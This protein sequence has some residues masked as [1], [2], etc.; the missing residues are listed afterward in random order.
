MVLHGYEDSFHETSSPWFGDL[1]GT[2][3]VHFVPRL[4]AQSKEV[5]AM[6][7]LVPDTATIIAD[8]RKLIEE[9]RGRASRKVNAELSLL[10][11]NVGLRLRL[12]A[13]LSERA[14]YGAKILA[15]VSKKL[16]EDFGRGWSVTQLRYCLRLQKCSPTKFLTH[17]VRN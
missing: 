1:W 11:W 5:S 10:Y 12:E 3:F 7:D 13:G 15:R 14:E 8:L 6:A 16:S 2:K 17:C 4:G 9:S